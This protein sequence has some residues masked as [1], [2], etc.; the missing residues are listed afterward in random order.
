MSVEDRLTAIRNA[1]FSWS[2]L[3]FR[4]RRGAPERN[5]VVW[6]FDRPN[7]IALPFVEA[8]LGLKAIDIK[9]QVLEAISNETTPVGSGPIDYSDDTLA[10]AVARLDAAY[11]RDLDEI[12]RM[13]GVTLVRH[14]AISPDRHL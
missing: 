5:L 13:E 7:A 4:I 14:E 11:E 10:R 1:R 6:D 9:Q 3:V 2:E 8:M 12:E